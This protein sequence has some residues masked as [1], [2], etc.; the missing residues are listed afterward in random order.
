MQATSKMNPTVVVFTDE[1]TEGATEKD[2][3]PMV[4]ALMLQ[5]PELKIGVIERDEVWSRPLGPTGQ[6]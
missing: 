2:V 6:I 4:R 5:F 3:A 1:N